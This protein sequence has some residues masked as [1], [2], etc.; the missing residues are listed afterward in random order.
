V[1]TLVDLTPVLAVGNVTEQEVG[2]VK[3][4]A[5][6]RA[7]LVTGAIVNGRIRYVSTEATEATRTFRVE[8]ELDN[9]ARSTIAGM[10][11]EIR[12]QL[13]ALKVHKVSPAVLTLADDGAVG[14]KAVDDLGQVQFHKA[15]LVAEDQ[16]GVWIAGL[17][18]RLMII[19]VG[20]EFVRPGQ[21]VEP[22][23]H[24]APVISRLK[25]Q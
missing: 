13:E 7:K 2:L 24:E 19:T 4:G 22:V 20:Q 17:P 18:D 1:A 14:V 3:V 5:A 12:F 16:D 6:G 10:T 8:M 11:A 25:G 15:E 9:S 23:P 21:K